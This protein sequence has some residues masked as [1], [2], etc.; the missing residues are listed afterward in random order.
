[1]DS[2]RVNIDRST[3][4]DSC[5]NREAIASIEASNIMLDRRAFKLGNKLYH[6]LCGP[7]DT[8][9]M[10]EKDTTKRRNPRTGIQKQKEV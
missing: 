9:R 8:N 5:D 10:T 3:V 1:M 7:G 2:A 6:K 4:K